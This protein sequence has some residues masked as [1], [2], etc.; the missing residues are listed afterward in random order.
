[1]EWNAEV[2]VEATADERQ[3]E[4][5]FVVASDLDAIATTD[6]LTRLEAHQGMLDIALVAHPLATGEPMEVYVVIHGKLAQLADIG[7][8]AI[9]QDTAG[10]FFDG[11]ANIDGHCLGR[12]A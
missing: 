6:A 10:G 2:Y 5:L 8:G 9:A 12:L 7:L 1:M 4:G 3:A 11:A